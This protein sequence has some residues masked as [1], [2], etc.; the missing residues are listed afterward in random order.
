M[1]FIGFL[2]LGVDLGQLYVVKNELQNVADGAALA[3]AKKLL[4]DKNNDGVPE[5]YCDEAKTAA[6]KCAEKNRSMGAGDSIKISE[7]DITIGQWD[8]KTKAFVRTGCSA[9]PSQANAVQVMVK[10]T[11]EDGGNPKVT[12]FFGGAIRTGSQKD[13]QA[14]AT[15]LMG[16]AGT[17]S[18]NPP[19]AVPPSWTSGDGPTDVTSNGLHRL[20][21]KFGPAPAY[22]A[23]PKTYKFYDKGGGETGGNLDTTR[24]TFVLAEESETKANALGNLKS[25][26]G[27]KMFPQKKV[28]E[29]LYPVSEYNW[30][31][32]IKGVFQLLKAKWTSNKDASGKWRVTLPVYSVN[33]VTASVPQ[34]SWFRLASRLIPGVSQAH[35][36]AAFGP[37]YNQGFISVDITDVH[38]QPNCKTTDYNQV[39]PPNSCRNTCYAEIEPVNQNTL[40]TDKGSNPTPYQKDYKAMNSSATEG[41]GVFSATPVIVK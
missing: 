7:G 19:L 34:D 16:N 18:I 10:R 11:G 41:V 1:A 6:I 8:V 21:D 5:V 17:S 36:C 28:G 4:Q 3:G 24:A 35:A 26:L 14:V 40:S 13:S 29:K 39:D 30:G 33:P 22:A 20:L 31:G 23:L 25:Y 37:V 12:T 38:V 2:A 15:A 9:N 32:N 27:G